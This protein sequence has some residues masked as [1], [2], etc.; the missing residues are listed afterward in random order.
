MKRAHLF[1]LGLAALA[2]TTLAAGLWLRLREGHGDALDQ[3]ANSMTLK[4]T[5]VRRYEWKNQ[6]KK[7]WQVVSAAPIESAAE[8]DAR[9]KTRG[10]CAPG[11]VEVEGE[12]LVDSYGTELSDEV[13]SAQ[14][15]TCLT[16]INRD[17]PARCADFDKNAWLT[18]RAT[19]KK[20]KMHFCIDRFEYPNQRGAYPWIV[21]TY[22]ESAAI[23]K[24]EG[25]RL[26]T[27]SEWTFAC[28]GEDASPYPGS[29]ERSGAACVT[30]QDWR[31][32]DSTA[33]Y[34][35][36]SEKAE[37]EVDRLWQGEASGSR[38][39]CRSSFGVYDMTGNVDEWTTSVRKTGYRSVLKGGYWGPVR[40]RCRPATRAHDE[41]FVAYQQGFRCC[42]APGDEPDEPE[43]D[44]G[45]PALAQEDAG[46]VEDAGAVVVDAGSMLPLPSGFTWQDPLPMSP[47]YGLLDEDEEL[48]RKVRGM[49]RGCGGGP[50]PR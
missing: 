41:H 30:D 10:R 18:A 50:A 48:E 46:V 2:S 20:K 23:C 29:F 37:R 8:T 47:D 16:W 24:R 31:E 9:E 25:K 1:A 34:N 13:E 12:F 44:E 45:E 22:M 15:K 3:L 36:T 43:V 7:H 5:D 14:S 33:F 4:A 27:E 35:R 21:A 42:G 32:F 19:F 28:E 38:E 11:M 49:S 39:S 17:F 6:D 40:A 26:C